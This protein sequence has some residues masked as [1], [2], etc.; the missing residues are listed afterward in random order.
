A[1]VHQARDSAERIRRA[2]GATEGALSV[3]CSAGVATFPLHAADAQS[4]VKSADAALYES[5]RRGRDRTTMAGQTLVDRGE[6]WVADQTAVAELQSRR[7][8]AR[9]E[10]AGPE[11]ARPEDARVEDAQPG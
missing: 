10:D 6:A 2:I 9:T 4:L 1:D 5:K 7:D 11:D 8:D 3:T